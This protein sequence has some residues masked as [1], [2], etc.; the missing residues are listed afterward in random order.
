MSTSKYYKYIMEWF[1]I[2]YLTLYL[3][4]KNNIINILWNGFI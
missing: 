2:K 3:S 4:L 1:H